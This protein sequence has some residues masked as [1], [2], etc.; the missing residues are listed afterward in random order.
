[1]LVSKKS[2]WTLWG[3]GLGVFALIVMSSGLLQTEVAPLGIIDHQAA[4]SAERI[5]EIQQSWRAAGVLTAAR[6]SMIA[7]FFFITL[8][9]LGGIIGGRL[10]WREGYNPNL[11]KLGLLSII[12]YAIFWICD[13]IETGAQFYQLVQFRGSD[14]LAETAAIAQPVKMVFF[15]LALLSTILCL[16]WLRREK[17]AQPK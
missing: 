16:I 17:A 2:F 10:I 12:S 14:F 9:G 6:W 13:Y 11:K 8:Y 1:M 5:D 15:T 4:G 3:S 7:D